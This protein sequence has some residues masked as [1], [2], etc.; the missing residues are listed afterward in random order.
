MVVSTPDILQTKLAIPPARTELVARPRL[1]DQFNSG[2][3]RP[4]TLICAPAGFGKTTLVSSWLESNS[5]HMMPVAWLSLDED[6]NDP[7][8]FLTYLICALA[9]V[10]NMEGESVL[11]LL[12]S[13]QPPPPKVLLT[14]LLNRL[15]DLPHRIALVLDDYHLVT[16]PSIHEAMTFLL[17]H[18]PAQ[19]GIVVTSREDPPFPLARMRA[20]GQLS[21]IRADDLRFTPDEAG[22]FLA[23]M[24]GVRLSAD[25]IAHL[26]ARTEGWIA[27]LQL[28]ALAMKGRTELSG[29]ISAFTGSHRYIL[30]YL[31]E[32]VLN[33]QPDDIQQ[34]LLQTSVLDRL[35]GA[36]CDA[37]TGRNDSQ[38]LLEGVER[39]NLFL[40]ALDDDR[41]WYRYHHLFGDMLRNHLRQVCTSDEIDDLHRHASHWFAD[42]HLTDEA[43]SHAIEAKDFEL[44][45]SVLEQSGTRYMIDSWGNFAMKWAAHIP[46]VVMQHHPLLA[47]NTGLWYSY[48]GQAAQAYKQIET[49]RTALATNQLPPSETEELLGYAD[50]VEALTA[51]V[52]R[53]IDRALAAAENA[54]QRLPQGHYRLRVSALF[55]RAFIA[56][57]LYKV[58]DARAIYAQIIE[59]ARLNGDSLI[60][61]RAIVHT[62]EAYA[63][64]G[65]M[66]DAE[67]T[68]SRYILLARDAPPGEAVSVGNAYAG[69]ALIQF[70]QNRLEEA[71]EAAAQCVTRSMVE[72]VLPYKLLTAY[73]VLAQTMRLSGD[74]AGLQSAVQHIRHTL[75]AYPTMPS[76]MFVL[77]ATHLWVIDDLLPVFHQFLRDRSGIKNNVFETQAYE[78]VTISMLLD[79]GDDNA[80]Q[81]AFAHVNKLR[82]LL[83]KAGNPVRWLEFYILE[84]LAYHAV[85]RTDDAL[86][87]LSE[88]LKLAE[89]EGFVRAFV[90]EGAPMTTLLKRAKMRGIGGDFVATLLAAFDDDISADDSDEPPDQSIFSDLEPLSERELDVL[91]LIA[92]GAS[93]REVAEELVIS[94]GTVKKH[95]NNIF[96]KLDASN[97]TQAVATARKYHVL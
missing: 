20:R 72:Y 35:N 76:R 21:E 29:F 64:E 52:N 32:E 23:Q 90:D 42:N 6:D 2:L 91:R 18:L 1:T 73:G 49:A 79:K 69:M 88:A 87:S 10:V 75:D 86:N 60:E 77:Y 54:L 70:A 47:L 71:A 62:G 53:D 9:N 26:D 97:R 84:S 57:A 63:L 46:E 4:L 80:L 66:H 30:D 7:A 13:P 24:L 37:V 17:E 81:E 94:V 41:Y 3:S 27:G 25:Q 11:A 36:L 5:G 56:Q 68:Y 28:A 45:A 92:D 82:E 50:T 51:G 67:V 16:V 33:Q 43:V 12:Q 78:Y 14:A 19:M 40:I 59:I 22:Q 61:A 8:R 65:R 93:N 44:A 89:P 85:G 74:A 83:F 34:F 15:E 95:L 38:Y 39:G 96:L 58:A 31:T 48:L 55:T